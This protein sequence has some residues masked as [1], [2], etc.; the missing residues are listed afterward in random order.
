MLQGFEAQLSCADP[1]ASFCSTIVAV[2][3]L[4]QC[5]LNI[6]FVCSST[7]MGNN[8]CNG[9]PRHLQKHGLY[10]MASLSAGAGE[11]NNKRAML[12]WAGFCV[13][14]M[15]LEMLHNR[16]GVRRWLVKALGAVDVPSN[17][18]PVTAEIGMSDYLGAF[19]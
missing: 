6:K 13:P 8:S 4:L 10:I 5:M 18:P 11:P 3:Y 9:L 15:L 19:Q 14:Q 1:S 2:Q 16:P 7:Y 17:A 12:P